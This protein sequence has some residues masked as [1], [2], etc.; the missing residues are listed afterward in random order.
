MTANKKREDIIVGLVLIA[1]C[2]VLYLIVPYQIGGGGELGELSGLFPK[3]SLVIIGGLSLILLLSRLIKKTEKPSVVTE[4]RTKI[5]IKISQSLGLIIGYVFLI[6]V[7]GFII[8]TFIFLAVF[9]KFFGEK[10]LLKIVFATSITTFGLY[11][12]LRILYI[13]IPDGLIDPFRQ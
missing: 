3:I 1:L 7:F 13:P 6:D 5:Y 10:S 4:S 11:F 2:A 9:I 12:L 8:S